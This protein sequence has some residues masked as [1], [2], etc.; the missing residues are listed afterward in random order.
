M[1]DILHARR[2]SERVRCMGDR[3]HALTSSVS[4]TEWSCAA[5]TPTTR[6]GDSAGTAVGLR[7]RGGTNS[8]MVRAG[9]RRE[10]RARGKLEA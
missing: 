3:L 2:D 1:G 8:G 5:S 7:T 6:K 9:E 10:Q 4:A